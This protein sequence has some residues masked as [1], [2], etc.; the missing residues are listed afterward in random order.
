MQNSFYYCERN[1]LHFLAEPL[2]F[3]TNLLFIVFS[4]LLLKNKKINKNKNTKKIIHVKTGDL[5][6]FPASLLHYTI[7]FRSK[8]QRIVLA[9]DVVPS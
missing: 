1:S 9:F 3:F 5:C 6:L 4:I 8:E 2:N 7:P